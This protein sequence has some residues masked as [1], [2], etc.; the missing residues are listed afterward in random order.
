MHTMER[1]TTFPW[2]QLARC[3]G[4]DPE[5]FHPP[6]EE[7]GEDAKAICTLCPVREAC[8]EHALA[9]REKF[10]VWGGY[11]ER[12]RRREIRRRRRSA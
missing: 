9:A 5:I 11:T 12:E 1:T 2:Q 3:K 6:A 10:G 4:V 7:E 8:L